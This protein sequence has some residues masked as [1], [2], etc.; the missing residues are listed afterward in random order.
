M[1]MTVFLIA[2]TALFASTLLNSIASDLQ[3]TGNLL[4]TARALCV[5]EAGAERAIVELRQDF[6]WDDGYDEVEFPS[7]SGQT[8]TV[9]IENSHP[10]IVITSTGTA[11]GF[12][13]SIEVV[14]NLIETSSP[15]PLRVMSWREVTP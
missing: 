12:E 1:L 2:F 8:Y 10:T 13:R 15:Y 5:A 4:A 7:G 6:E 11:A 3:I 9:E 14:V